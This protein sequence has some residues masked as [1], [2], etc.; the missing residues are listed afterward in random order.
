VNSLD[1]R[2]LEAAYS[3]LLPKTIDAKVKSLI[4]FM[5]K[6]DIQP[7]FY[8]KAKPDCLFVKT[9]DDLVPLFV[10][11][12]GK[13]KYKGLT[14]YNFQSVG[15]VSPEIW[16]LDKTD[17]L[18]PVSQEGV[19]LNIVEEKDESLKYEVNKDGSLR[20]L[21]PTGC[22]V[23]EHDGDLIPDWL[24]KMVEKQP[25]F[26][27]WNTII[28]PIISENYLIF[29]KDNFPS[30]IKPVSTY[31]YNEPAYISTYT[32]YN[33]AYDY[34]NS[35]NWRGPFISS[36]KVPDLKLKIDR[37]LES[38]NE[39]YRLINELKNTIISMPNM[40]CD[41][42][43]S[44]Y[45]PTYSLSY[46]SLNST[47]HYSIIDVNNFS[48]NSSIFVSTFASTFESAFV[49]STFVETTNMEVASTLVAPT[50]VEAAPTIVETTSS[51]TVIKAGS[52]KCCTV[53]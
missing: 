51:G 28:K 36:I 32:Q 12:A 6:H 26:R 19:T 39:Q 3:E 1:G 13:L 14:G 45:S 41:N 49:T 31:T 11:F 7:N 43:V 29:S 15:L 47:P 4:I 37:L 9:E 20:W 5:I 33:N 8:A 25:E 24:R 38:N 10:S 50:N 34:D 44:S 52:N 27:G 40:V 46:S 48:S 53:V 2:G 35:K 42:T 21:L 22:W 23:S 30:K 17:T 18:I 16:L